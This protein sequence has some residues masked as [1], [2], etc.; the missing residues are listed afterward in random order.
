MQ[1]QIQ[2]DPDHGATQRP[3]NNRKAPF[4]KT[5]TLSA[6][7]VHRQKW[8]RMRCRHTCSRQPQYFSAHSAMK[9]SFRILSLRLHVFVAAS[10][11][12]PLKNSFVRRPTWL[13][14]LLTHRFASDSTP[15]SDPRPGQNMSRTFLRPLPCS[16]N[17]F[18]S[19]K[20]SWPLKSCGARFLTVLPSLLPSLWQAM[21]TWSQCELVMHRAA[22]SDTNAL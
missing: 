2:K 10:F 18:S 16:G 17:F 21:R 11:L 15:F 19:T 12:Q 1:L 8:R 22:R 20:M 9:I 3:T 4:G 6:A 7:F 13:R 14:A 5:G